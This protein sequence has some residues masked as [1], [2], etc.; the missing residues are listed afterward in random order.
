MNGLM[1]STLI[2]LQIYK[3]KHVTVWYSSLNVDLMTQNKENNIYQFNLGL[4]DSSLYL[5]L[6][7]VS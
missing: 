2:R 7:G 4:M 3:L 6:A 1:V 5:G